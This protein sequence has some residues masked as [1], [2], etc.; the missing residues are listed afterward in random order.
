MIKRFVRHDSCGHKNIASISKVICLADAKPGLNEVITFLNT[1]KTSVLINDTTT[2]NP[3]SMLA[4]IW[5]I[6]STHIKWITVSLELKMQ[7]KGC[8]R[9][10]LERRQDNMSTFFWCNEIKQTLHK[11]NIKFWLLLFYKPFLYYSFVE[12]LKIRYINLK[13]TVLHRNKTNYF[14]M[15]VLSQGS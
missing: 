1:Y 6:I 15:K 5:R 11:S 9:V 3:F 14:I 12:G 4:N 13:G 7:L 2:W 10:N 8:M